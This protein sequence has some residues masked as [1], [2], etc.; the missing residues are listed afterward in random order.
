MKMSKMK[1]GLIIAAVIAVIIICVIIYNKSIKLDDVKNSNQVIDKVN[2]EI[3]T[4]DLTLTTV[5]LGTICQKL[6][7]AMDGLGTDTEAVYNAFALANTRSDV[8]AIIG[9]FGVKDGETLSEW[10]YGDLSG[11]EIMHLNS[12]IASKG[13]NYKF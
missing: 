10:L 3:D 7:D 9:T 5:Q 8:L 12:L 1:I 4:N 2:K 11:S 13:I 6:Y